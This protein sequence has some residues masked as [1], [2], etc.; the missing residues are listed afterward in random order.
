MIDNPNPNNFYSKEEM[1]LRE[2]HIPQTKQ[3]LLE[4]LKDLTSKIENEEPFPHGNIS[5]D[6]LGDFADEIDEML[7]NWNY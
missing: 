5:L 6:K 1:V 4:R 3:I 7:N 2:K